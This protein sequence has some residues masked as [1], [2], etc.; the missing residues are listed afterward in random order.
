VK[1]PAVQQQTPVS[2]Q[3]PLLP[4][5]TIQLKSCLKKSTGDESGQ[6]TGNGS[7]SKGN[8]RVKFMLVG[9][10]SS[11]GEPLIVGNKNNNAN[12]SDGGAPS[13]AMDFISKNIQKVTTSSQPPLLPTPPQFLKNPQHNLRNSE[14]AMSS[15]NNPNF[16]NT[17][18]ASAAAAAT[19]VDISHQMITLLTRC[20]DVV[21]NLTGILGYVPYHPL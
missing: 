7:S 2:S 3:K 21:T 20:S 14:L 17:T 15:R 1:D 18:T 13:V 4:L 6:G 9:E 19:S 5:P 12:L 16:I 11:R 8:P 10:E